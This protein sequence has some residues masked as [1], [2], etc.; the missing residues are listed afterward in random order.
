MIVLNKIYQGNSLDVLKSFPSEF[1]DMAITSP[2]YYGLRSYGTEPQ[3]WDGNMDCEHEW[4]EI[5]IARPNQSGG[6][7]KKQS[8]NKGSFAV[9]YNDRYSYSHRCAKCNAWKGELGQ[10]ET[11]EEYIKHLCDIFD[12]VYRVLKP[13]GSLW[14]NIA[15]T[16]IP[17]GK[18]RK[19]LYCVPDLFK[20]EM[21]YNRGWL[22][23]ME[24]IWYKPN[25]M[26]TS[27]RDRFNVDYE[28]MFHFVKQ[29]KYYFKQQREP[30][31]DGTGTRIKRSVWT[32]NNVAN[33]KSHTATFPK[34]LVETP[35]KATCPENGIVLDMF[36]GSGTVFEVC[37]E[38]NVNFVGIELNEN[39]IKEY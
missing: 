19:G 1:I 32:I 39:F 31:A 20:I 33:S 11:V 15:D 26:P 2:P 9:E 36:A 35:I 25:Q 27:V 13:E 28:K 34:E 14:V 22:C 38:N 4:T 29:P 8:T 37:K 5:K 24:I 3:I 23:R 6:K 10:E 21:Q 18:F 30:T 16:Y 12:E 17:I 7:T